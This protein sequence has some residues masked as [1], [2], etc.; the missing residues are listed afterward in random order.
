MTDPFYAVVLSG[1]RYHL[2]YITTGETPRNT[3]ET[4]RLYCDAENARRIL[5]SAARIERENQTPN[6]PSENAELFK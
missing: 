2:A 6:A 3:V 4:H 5:E 1:N